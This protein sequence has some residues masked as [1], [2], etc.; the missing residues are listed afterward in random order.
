MFSEEGFGNSV[1]LL[2]L[3][4]QVFKGF[5]FIFAKFYWLISFSVILFANNIAFKMY[6]RRK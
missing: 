5:S 3:T 6:D 1:T 4:F 2:L